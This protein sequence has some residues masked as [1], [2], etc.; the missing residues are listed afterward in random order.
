MAEDFTCNML[1]TWLPRTIQQFE[2]CLLEYL[3]PLHNEVTDEMAKVVKIGA[4][5]LSKHDLVLKL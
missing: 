3:T 1:K 4:L 2:E 5:Q